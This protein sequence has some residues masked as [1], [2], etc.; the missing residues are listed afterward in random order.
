MAAH[1]LGSRVVS[2]S[3]SSGSGTD[4]PRRSVVA[5]S[6]PGTGRPSHSAAPRPNTFGGSFS[7]NLGCGVVGSKREECRSSRK[8]KMDGGSSH[9]TSAASVVSPGEVLP[10][11]HPDAIRRRT[12]AMVRRQTRRS[13]MAELKRGRGWWELNAP[14]NLISIDNMAQFQSY[15]EGIKGTSQL[16]VVD[17]FA[18]WCRACR[19]LFP[20]LKQIAGDNPD[21]CAIR[22]DT[23][24][25]ATTP[26]LD[27]RCVVSQLTTIPGCAGRF[28][29]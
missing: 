24:L 14:S 12:E 22:S 20:K 11:M 25:Q 13:E 7:G 18:P 1:V 17:F 16:V 4:A 28:T 2:A 27:G 6:S 5:S 3:S 10:M 23:F 19:T 29:S 8:A 21:V 26:L 15:L 9:P